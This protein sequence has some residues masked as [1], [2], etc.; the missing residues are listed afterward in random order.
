MLHL[1]VEETCR[2][3]LFLATNYEDIAAFVNLGWVDHAVIVNASNL[4]LPTARKFFFVNDITENHESISELPQMLDAKA[5]INKRMEGFN[6][7][8]LFRPYNWSDDFELENKTVLGNPYF[9]Y[10]SLSRK[11]HQDTILYKHG[12]TVLRD[13]LRRKLKE[14]DRHFLL[15]TGTDDA[16]DSSQLYFSSDSTACSGVRTKPSLEQKR[17]NLFLRREKQISPSIPV[18]QNAV[19][20]PDGIVKYTPKISIVKERSSQLSYHGGDFLAALK[21]LDREEIKALTELTQHIGVCLKKLGYLGLINCDYVIDEASREIYFVEVNPRYSA[22]TFLLDRF[23][24]TNWD[25]LAEMRDIMPSVLHLAS[26][27][28]W[29]TNSKLIETHYDSKKFVTIP[30]TNEDVSSFFKV[31]GYMAPDG[32]KCRAHEEYWAIRNRTDSDDRLIA[33][34]LS[35]ETIVTDP[36]FPVEVVGDLEAYCQP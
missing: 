3:T 28:G 26:F 4:E 20:L 29:E 24:A 14:V 10:I 11:L 31:F 16:L 1:R 2:D 9:E 5:Y 13:H 22:C 33:T 19:I 23:F 17:T 27:K 7:I 21:C 35:K 12:D 18:C 34:I 8:W 30:F 15:T 32:A 36:V 6:N 25:G